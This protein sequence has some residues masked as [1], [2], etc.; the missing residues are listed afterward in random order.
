MSR[1]APEPVELRR[2][3]PIRKERA[4]A[5]LELKEAFTKRER[6]EEE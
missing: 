6:K 3:A 2:A 5:G 4:D 1:N